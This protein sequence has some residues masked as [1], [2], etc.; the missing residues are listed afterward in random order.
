M[1]NLILTKENQIALLTINRPKFKNALDGKTYEEFAMAIDEI[2]EDSTIRVLIIT[3]A[4]DSF[5]SGLDLNFAASI[6]DLNQMEFRT[7]LKKFKAS[8][9]LRI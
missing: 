4:G 9:C 6:K 1:E 2:K 3:G 7:T 8:L 5:C